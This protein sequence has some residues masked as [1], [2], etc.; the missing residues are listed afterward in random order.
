MVRGR[1]WLDESV[2]VVLGAL[3]LYLPP[4]G[5]LERLRMRLCTAGPRSADLGA[6]RAEDGS[7][8]GGGS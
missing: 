6:H 8:A 4:E 5:W 3:L 7:A 1:R 2:G